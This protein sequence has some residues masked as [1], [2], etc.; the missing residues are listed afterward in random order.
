MAIIKKLWY[1]KGMSENKLLLRNQ[2]SEKVIGVNGNGVEEDP[3]KGPERSVGMTISTEINE[4]SSGSTADIKAT[5]VQSGVTG[6]FNV[7]SRASSFLH[8]VYGAVTNTARSMKSLAN[9]FLKA[10]QEKPGPS[11]PNN[12]IPV[13]V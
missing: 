10:M 12:S 7:K 8:F 6:T 3:I 5:A 4:E 13:Q 9:R 1:N 11:F 2:G